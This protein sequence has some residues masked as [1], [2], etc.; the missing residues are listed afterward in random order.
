MKNRIYKFLKKECVKDSNFFIHNIKTTE[1]GLFT[2]LKNEDGSVIVFALIILVIVTI[3]GIT[4]T[5]NSNVEVQIAANDHF[6]KIA[7][8][9]SDAGIYATPKLISR[10]INANSEITEGAGGDAPGVTYLASS[11]TY[12]TGDFYRQLLGYDAY[13]GGAPDIDYA[14]LS[15]EVDVER[16]RSQ[17]VE[18]GGAEFATGSEGIGVGSAGG[19]AVYY[20][21]YSDGTGPRNST[22]SLEAEYRKVVGMAGGL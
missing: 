7:F 6:H 16:R 10:T 5:E 14:A 19:V 13:D 11:G 4:S 20:G 12:T 1:K 9:N 2:F 15:T 22:T 18:G 3:M 8:Y 17:H 21:L